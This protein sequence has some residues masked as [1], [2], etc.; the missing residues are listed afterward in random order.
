[1]PMDQA[2]DEAVNHCLQLIRKCRLPDGAFRVKADGDPV[3]IQPYFA[4]LAALA[5][6]A[7]RNPDDLDEVEGWLNWYALKQSPDGSIN[8]FEGRLSTGYRSNGKRDSVDAYAGTYLLTVFRYYVANH[9]KP[10]PASIVIAAKKSLSAIKSL[11]EKDGLTWAKPDYRIKY[12]MDNIETYSGLLAAERLFEA[13]A[14][15]D[16]AVAKEMRTALGKKLPDYWQ[17]R[18]GLF[19]YALDEQDQFQMRSD[20]P[21]GHRATEGLANLYAL[22]WVS[23]MDSRPWKHVV[24]EFKP[25]GGNAPEAPVERWYIA[26]TA[27]GTAE[28]AKEWRRRTIAEANE[29][30][31]GNIYIH[32]AAV[33]VLA[34][35]EGAN[36]LPSLRSGAK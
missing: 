7:G 30:A 14:D 5:L 34:L 33:A 9:G 35:R 27:A 25:D 13:I 28:E 3:W 36:W 8:D 4:N 23:S 22:A 2:G 26:A 18:D 15:P 20:K 24:K 32:R 11:Q 21:E 31:S 29:F 19:A 16:A 1:M 10:L 17:A 12:L 6:L